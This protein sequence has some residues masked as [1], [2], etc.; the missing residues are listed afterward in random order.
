MCA[1]KV[2]NSNYLDVV[3]RKEVCSL[4]ELSTPMSD[5]IAIILKLQC[6]ACEFQR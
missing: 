6:P 4:V 5:G 2:L 3:P 1:L